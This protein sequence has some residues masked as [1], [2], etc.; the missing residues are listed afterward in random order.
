[1]LRFLLNNSF[2]TAFLPFMGMLTMS[3]GE[4]GGGSTDG[5]NGDEPPAA[6][7]AQPAAEPAKEPAAPAQVPDDPYKIFEGLEGDE[8]FNKAMAIRRQPDKHKPGE[9][10]AAY[11]TLTNRTVQARLDRM[12]KKYEGRKYGDQDLEAKIAEARK[13]WE[14][15]RPAVPEQKETDPEIQEYLDSF[16]DPQQRADIAKLLEFQDKK[17]GRENKALRDELAKVRAPIEEAMTSA[18]KRARDERLQADADAIL[19][20]V[21]TVDPFTVVEILEKNEK[22][23]ED[24]RMTTEEMIAL[25]TQVEDERFTHLLPARLQAEDAPT[26]ALLK[27]TVMSAVKANKAWASELLNDLIASYEEAKRGAP[28]PDR[29]GAPK[30][31]Q[32]QTA[33]W[34]PHEVMRG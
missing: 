9:I 10:K 14:K 25:A 5:G 32:P 30:P 20:K 7:A 24:Q 17:L 18:Q 31:A 12:A 21:K 19:A 8:A 16:T 27:D 3:I 4:D 13:Q 26:I 29:G 33:K 1:M 23:P 6:P 2:L 28:A 22:L 15:E 34:D 11:D